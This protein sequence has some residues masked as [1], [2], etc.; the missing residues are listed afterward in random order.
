[1]FR[2]HL[3]DA[4]R[5]YLI[6]MPLDEVR[7][8]FI[9]F[10]TRNLWTLTVV[11]QQM[12]GSRAF[13]LRIKAVARVGQSQVEDTTRSQN[14]QLMPKRGDWVLHML[15]HVIRN[16]EIQRRIGERLKAR[17]VIDH[18]GDDQWSTGAQST[19]VRLP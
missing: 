3:T 15:E 2:L 10:T 11:S 12:L 1:M 18:I 9:M 17:A 6:T 8:F 5:Q 7:A 16:D 19:A 14:P 13:A 4:L